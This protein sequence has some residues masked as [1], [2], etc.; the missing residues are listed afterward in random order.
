MIKTNVFLFIIFIS[1]SVIA[2]DQRYF[3]FSNKGTWKPIKLREYKSIEINSDCSKN[4]DA[5]KLIDL[6]PNKNAKETMPNPA[7]SFCLSLDGENVA[8][9]DQKE[10]R[11]HFCQLK[12]KSLFNTWQAMSKK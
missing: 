6:L 7:Q 9:K 3:V 5:K 12:D 1:N 10:N 2:I 11:Y 8:I 4:C